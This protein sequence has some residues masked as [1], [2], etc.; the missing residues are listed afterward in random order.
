[1][2]DFFQRQRKILLAFGLAFLLSG[3]QHA[4]DDLGFRDDMPYPAAYPLDFRPPPKA[5]GTIYQPGYDV[6]LFQDHV[7][8]HI[9]DVLT[10]R[11]EEA[12]TGEKQAKTKTTKSSS[13]NTNLGSG[14]NSNG[15][16]KPILMGGVLNSA[17]FNT[18]AELDF[19]GKGETNEFNKLRGTISVTVYCVLSNGNLLV[20]GETWITINQGKEFIRLSGIVR[21]E[22]I[23]ANNIVSS[24]RIAN[25]RI[26]YTGNGQVNN[27]SHGG[28]ITQLL[29]KW[30]PY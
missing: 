9:G 2:M 27:S 25:A 30:F 1:M 7:A 22:D 8:R 29:F 5:N 24:Q 13:D 17:I 16:T 20:R 12:T 4:M 6:S 3:C 14:V 23:S 11:L 10:V 15:T 19:N 26:S 21:P 18:G 28:I